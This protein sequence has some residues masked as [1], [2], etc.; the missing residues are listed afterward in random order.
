MRD[1]LLR[2]SRD[3]DAARAQAERGLETI[4][5]RHTCEHRA[6]QL[7]GIVAELGAAGRANG[8]AATTA[9]SPPSRTAAA[10]S[11]R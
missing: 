2:L 11:A 4:L 9:P 3:E 6:E 10:A 5:A 1:A 7:L 8:F